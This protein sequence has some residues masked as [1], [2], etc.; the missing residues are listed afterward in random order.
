MARPDLF[1]VLLSDD[2]GQRVAARHAAGD[3]RIETDRAVAAGLAGADLQSLRFSS[4]VCNVPQLGL[5]GG[6]LRV[7]MAV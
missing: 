2:R 7:V 3:L 5:W 4:C 6:A 1:Y